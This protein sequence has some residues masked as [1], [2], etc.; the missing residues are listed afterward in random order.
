MGFRLNFLSEFL[1]DFR[2]DTG[3]LNFL[4]GDGEF[5]PPSESGD[6]V[7]PSG[8]VGVS[9]PS[10]WELEH[11]EVPGLERSDV[12]S[13][14]TCVSPSLRSSSFSNALSSS[15]LPDVL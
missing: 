14:C 15:T 4:A 2:G 5:M 13:S 11:N 3:F 12:C 6:A 1:S 9:K 7:F 8:S 10:V